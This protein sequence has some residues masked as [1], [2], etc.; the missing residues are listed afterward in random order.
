MPAKEAGRVLVSVPTAVGNLL[1]ARA[2]E[3]YRSISN[4]A[5]MLIE[6]GLAAEKA[7]SG[8]N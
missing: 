1:R 5:A 4:E 3:N 6:R 7:A 2:K 8:Q